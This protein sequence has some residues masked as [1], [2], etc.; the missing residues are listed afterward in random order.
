[1][2]QRNDWQAHGPDAQGATGAADLACR[3]ED[4]KGVLQQLIDQLSDVDR[5][6]SAA[7][8]DMQGRLARMGGQ[9]ETV[10]AG[11]PRHLASAFA[12][13]EA[14]MSDLAERL[15]EA[16]RERIATPAPSPFEQHAPATD[17]SMTAADTAPSPKN[18]TATR[19]D[20]SNRKL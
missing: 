1:M 10:K 3:A 2:A 16:E 20:C 19:S 4:L 9:S 5:R 11:L 17:P 13:I 14:G 18:A 8:Q 15:S 7:L 12:R 6:Q